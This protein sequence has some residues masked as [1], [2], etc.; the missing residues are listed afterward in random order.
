MKT[1]RVSD[2]L[3]IINKISPA[4]LAESWDNPGLQV[5]DPAAGVSA[6]MVALDAT[7]AVIEAALRSGCQLLVTHHPLIFKAQKSISTATAQGRMIH[8]AIRGG[9]SIVCMH[10]NY[11][12]AGNGL[13]DLLAERLGITSCTPL[14]ITGRQEL[15]KLVVFVPEGHLDRLR[16]A[17]LPHGESLGSYRDCSFARSEYGKRFRNTGWNSWSTA[18]TCPGPSNP[19]WRPTPTRNRPSMSTLCSTRGA[20]LAWDESAALPVR[21]PWR[22]LPPLSRKGC[23]LPGHD[24]SAIPRHP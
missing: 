15:V 24:S 16:T 4:E 5:G 20:T 8:S 11:D 18:P 3:G 21:R 14:Q 7:P 6:V 10:T 2:I 22:P 19:C 12:I 23:R 13:N 9:L 17:L 1:A